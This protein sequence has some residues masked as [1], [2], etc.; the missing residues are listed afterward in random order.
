MKTLTDVTVA[1]H[2]ISLT[3]LTGKTVSDLY[4]GIR[5]DWGD[6]LITIYGI[7]F[8]DGTFASVQG[9]HDIVYIE[10]ELASQEQLELLL[11]DACSA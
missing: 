3:T 6:P 5:N 11:E 7:K 2:Y 9:E 1:K 4:C 10:D 8:S